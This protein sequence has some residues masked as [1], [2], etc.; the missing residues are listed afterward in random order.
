MPV[1]VQFPV[2]GLPTLLL[3]CVALLSLPCTFS[4]Y[5]TAALP[6]MVCSARHAGTRSVP[7]AWLA[8]PGAH[9]RVL[10]LN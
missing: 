3:T 7:H 4:D 1:R 8:Y 6:M 5:C 2:L 9:V 10:L